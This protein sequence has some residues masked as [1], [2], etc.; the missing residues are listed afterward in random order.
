[1]KNPPRI[2]PHILRSVAVVAN[3]DP[4]SVRR[5]IGGGIVRPLCAARITAALAA[6]GRTD[7]IARA[8]AARAAAGQA[9]E[10]A[11]TGTEP[12]RGIS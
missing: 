6:M 8:D 2:A 11:A 1:M 5:F 3:A 12:R 4:R 7:L 10:A 9:S